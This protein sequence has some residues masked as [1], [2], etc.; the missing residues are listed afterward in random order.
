MRLG[1]FDSGIGGEAVASSLRTA[2]PD[3]DIHIVNDREH[4]PYGDRTTDD[5]TKLTDAAIQP[6]LEAQCDVIVIACNSATAA[7]IDTLR[8]RYPNQLFIGLEPMVKP[9][10]SMT[11]S[12][13][14]AICATPATLSSKRYQTL[15]QRFADSAEI[16]EPDCS[17]WARMIEDNDVN[18][19]QIQQI[20][21]SV[22]AEGADVIVLACTH[23]HWILEVIEKTAAGRATVLDPSDAIARRVSELLESR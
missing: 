16:L 18:E 12:N 11:R 15:K 22:C 10:A 5:I 2:F 14:I 1:I 7:A 13:K 8:E 19:S 9:A 6:L 20:V 21:E 3:A 4:L 17:N 23:Y